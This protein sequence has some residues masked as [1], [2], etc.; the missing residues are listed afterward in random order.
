[1]VA[2]NS[3]HYECSFEEMK[4]ALEVIKSISHID[5]DQFDEL[6]KRREEPTIVPVRCASGR[7]A[8]VE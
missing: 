6:F 7:F 4:G 3:S 2:H 1:M 8:F 5:R